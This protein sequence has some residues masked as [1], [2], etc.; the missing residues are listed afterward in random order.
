MYTQACT[1]FDLQ[2]CIDYYA[3]EIY[4]GN[5]DWPVQNTSL[6]RTRKAESSLYGDCKWRWIL[7]D[8]DASMF[9]NRSEYDYVGRAIKKDPFFASLMENEGFKKAIEEKLV[10]LA[11]N[12]FD[13][14]RID[15]FITEYQ[16]TR[17]DALVNEYNRFYAGERTSE[18]F[19]NDCNNVREFF[20]RRYDY[21]IQTY[22][23]DHE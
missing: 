13:P 20:Y 12:N 1:L 3:A 23:G 9:V 5:E 18:D 11:N 16:A 10:E 22:G 2:S 6:W 7:F 17:V 21:I 8:C 19:N 14:Q 4:I 15:E